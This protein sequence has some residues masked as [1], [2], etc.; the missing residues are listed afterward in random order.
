MFDDFKL[1]VVINYVLLFFLEEWETQ[2]QYGGFAK[3]GVT[4][5]SSILIG[6]SMK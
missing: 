1:N 6:F 3:W 4:P 2:L 5:I